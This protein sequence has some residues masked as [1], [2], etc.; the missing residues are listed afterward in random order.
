MKRPF[1]VH[2][3]KKEL[4]RVKLRRELED[5]TRVCPQNCRYNQLVTLGGGAKVSL[6]TF[7]QHDPD[8]GQPVDVPKLLVCSTN[9][10]AR[11]CNARIPK[12]LTEEEAIESIKSDLNSRDY[13]IKNHPDVVALDWVMDNELHELQ[14]NPPG[15][16]VKLLLALARF[17]EDLS[18]KISRRKKSHKN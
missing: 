16:R 10:Q 17:F 8:D 3:K 6:C 4:L 13:L 7:G 9:R 11:E 5:R 1:D 12:Y 2:K 18:K 14:A 15:I